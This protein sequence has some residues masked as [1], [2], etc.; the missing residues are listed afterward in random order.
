MEGR[1]TLFQKRKTPLELHEEQLREDLRKTKLA[2]DTANSN[3]ENALDPDLIDCCIYELNA[4]QRRY[5]FLL[6]Q[7][8][9]LKKITPDL[10]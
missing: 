7:V 4:M 5:V 2:L 9:Q 8:D 1:D 10:G 3:F 6:R